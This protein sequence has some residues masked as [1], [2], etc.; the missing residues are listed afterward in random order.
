MRVLVYGA[1][2]PSSRHKQ[3]ATCARLGRILLLPELWGAPNA[4]WEHSPILME[5]PDVCNVRPESKKPVSS[6]C[7]ALAMCS[8]CCLL[9]CGG[10]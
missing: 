3:L 8:I 4:K 10:T 1:G 5:H 9:M 7:S 6:Q 2:S